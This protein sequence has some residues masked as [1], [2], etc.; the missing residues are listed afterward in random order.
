MQVP[1][2]NS[3]APIPLAAQGLDVA[4]IRNDTPRVVDGHLAIEF[5]RFWGAGDLEFVVETSTNLRTWTT[6]AGEV[7]DISLTVDQGDAFA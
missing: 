1:E 5:T 3:A 7:E 4:A 2:P 6:G